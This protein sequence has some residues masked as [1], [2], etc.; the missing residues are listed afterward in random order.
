VNRSTLLL[1]LTLVLS[2]F[3]LWR[4]SYRR[5]AAPDDV[6]IVGTNAE[7]PP[8]SFMVDNE[9]AGF[10]IDVA[11]EIAK[12]LSKQIQLKN[13]PFDALLPK[14]QLGDIHV[15]AA[16]MTATPERA[17]RVSFTQPYLVDDPLLIITLAQQK[18]IMNIHDLMG[19]TVAVNEG[20]TSDL[21]LSKYPEINLKR[22]SAP[23]EAFLALRSGR[24]DAFVAAKSSIKPFFDRYGT[25]EFT[26]SPIAGVHDNYALAISMHYPELLKAI[27]IALETMEKDGTLAA[28]RTK[29]SVQ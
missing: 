1:C 2:G 28:L 11:K 20:Y 25:Q 13:M 16:G 8:F 29:W 9:I 22:L 14:L 5:N 3:L 21:Y 18:P 17:Q 23:A 10:D 27:Q 24:V 6:L 12:R 15:I 26:Q 19:K 4:V 7:Y